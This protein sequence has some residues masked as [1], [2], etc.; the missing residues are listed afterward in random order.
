MSD[1]HFIKY[2]ISADAID[3]NTATKEELK[4][5]DGVGDAVAENIIK[6]RTQ[7]RPFERAEDL[8]LVNRFGEKLLEQNKTKIKVKK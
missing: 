7:T 1:S 6:F 8:L 5:L 3:I 4:T 2:E